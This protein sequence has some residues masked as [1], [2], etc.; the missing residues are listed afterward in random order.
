MRSRI[1][2]VSMTAYFWACEKATSKTLKAIRRR[3]FFISYILSVKFNAG[4]FHQPEIHPFTL[5]HYFLFGSPGL[6]G[7]VTQHECEFSSVFQIRC[8]RLN[9]VKTHA[10]V[11]PEQS[12]HRKEKAHTHAY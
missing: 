12:K 1:Y 10:I 8:S 2:L 6:F 5:I 3:N 11:K 4:F 7:F 9:P